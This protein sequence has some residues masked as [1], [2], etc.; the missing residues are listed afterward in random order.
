MAYYVYILRCTNQ[1]FYTGWTTDPL[2]RLQQHNNG[3]GA[4]YTRLNGPSKLVYLEELPDRGSAQK[5]E[6]EIK[7]LDHLHKKKLI[8]SN[9]TTAAQFEIESNSEYLLTKV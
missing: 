3:H 7:R 1:A 2:R 4:R 8:D 6:A 5:R 9:P